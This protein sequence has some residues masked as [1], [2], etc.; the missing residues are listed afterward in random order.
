[1]TM[2]LKQAGLIFVVGDGE[3]TTSKAGEDIP[4]AR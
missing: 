1:M 2:A 4:T 3:I